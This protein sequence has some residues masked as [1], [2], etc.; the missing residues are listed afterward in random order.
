MQLGL[1]DVQ[2]NEIKKYPWSGIFDWE[3]KEGDKC[4]INS[5]IIDGYGYTY[6]LKC[7]IKTIKPLV[8]LPIID[9]WQQSEHSEILCDIN[10]L[11]PKIYI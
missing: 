4:Q 9:K 10:D 3:P 2:N 11:W 1:F 8:L 7:V 6:G 5:V